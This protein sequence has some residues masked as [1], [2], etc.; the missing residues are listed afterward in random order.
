MTSKAETI[1]VIVADDHALVRGA[2]VSLLR[3]KAGIAVIGECGS[4][5][6]A[7]AM[8]RARRPDVALLDVS[9]PAPG[10]VD[11]APILAEECPATRV[12]I[13][14]MHCN[15]ML[16]AEALNGGARGYVL[17]DSGIEELE[18]AIRAV[19]G[20]GIHLSASVSRELARTHVLE[21]GSGRA[22]L[23]PRQRQVLRL[24]A[25]GK[26]ARQIAAALGLSVKTV[27]SHRVLLMHRLG[28]HHLPGLVKYAI[29]VGLAN[30]D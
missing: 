19:A 7:M 26:S 4:G 23:T 5:G 29:R 9:M 8:I 30:P 24:L 6:E 2:I 16:A 18:A 1:S 11:L 21:R 27:E 12:V 28:V 25:E 3:T 17:K 22:S 14:S 20:G 13:L 15:E 10:G